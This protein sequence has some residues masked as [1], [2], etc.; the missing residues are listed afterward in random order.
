MFFAAVFALLCALVMLV[1]FLWRGLASAV[2]GAV[3]WFAYA[4]Y[5]LLQYIRLVCGGNCSWGID[6]PFVIVLLLVSVAAIRQSVFQSG[7]MQ[8]DDREE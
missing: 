3:L 1:L 6:L 8:G 4:L 2:A 7:A 5:E